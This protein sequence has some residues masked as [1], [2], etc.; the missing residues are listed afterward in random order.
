LVGWLVSQVSN[1][2][3]VQS[4]NGYIESK[5]AV[6]L[7]Q[8]LHKNTGLPPPSDAQLQQEFL[9]FHNGKVTQQD[10]IDFLHLVE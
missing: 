2:E 1:V 3:I 5:Q 9:K 8:T 10:L 4:P 6:A 7:I